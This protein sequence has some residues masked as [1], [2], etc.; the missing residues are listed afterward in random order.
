MAFSINPPQDGDQGESQL[1]GLFVRAVSKAYLYCLYCFLPVMPLLAGIVFGKR[2]FVT[3]Y[4]QTFL[5]CV[6]HVRALA[7]GPAL[8]YF[9]EVAG[10]IAQVPGQMQGSC[11]QCG[12]CCME[13][14]CV[15]LEPMGERKFGCG[16][17][18]SYWR[19]F[20]NCGSFPMSQHDIDR[21]ACP[22][23]YVDEEAPIRFHRTSAACI[24]P[25][26]CS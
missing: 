18:N 9:T 1:R 23:Y 8:H 10:K 13:H 5:R 12:N 11:V 24:A 22:S 6:V 14:R 19:R 21:Y 17:Y 3:Q 7:E 2:R 4:R 25:S 20:S 15:F 26:T 16:I